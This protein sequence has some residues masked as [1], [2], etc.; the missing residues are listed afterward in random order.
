M[1]IVIRDNNQF[2]G[3]IGFLSSNGYTPL[4]LPAPI[5]VSA[6]KYTNNK[7]DKIVELCKRDSKII[8]DT[9]EIEII[10]NSIN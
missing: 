7:K 8:F 2:G 3:Y 6:N 10:D 9:Q 5:N 1:Q 4:Q